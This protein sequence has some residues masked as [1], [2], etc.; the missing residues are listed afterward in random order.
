MAMLWPYVFAQGLDIQFA[1]TSFP[2]SNNA[3]KNAGVTCVVVGIGRGRDKYIFTDALKRKVSSISP[4]L[5]E[6]PPTVVTKRSASVSDL[7][8]M[9]TGNLPSDGGHLLMTYS[10]GR[11]LVATHPDAK[12][13]LKK[14]VGSRELIN[15]GDRWCLWIDDQELPEALKID[16]IARRLTGV[17]AARESSRGDQAKGGVATPHRFVFSPHRSGYAV[18]IPKVSSA[19]REYIPCALTDDDTVVS[20]LARVI[21]EAPVWALALVASRLHLVWIATICGKLKTDF[22]YS[23]TLGWN[24]FPVPPLSEKNRHDLRACA[25]SILLVREA[26]F[27][28]TLAELYDPDRMPADLRDAHQRNDEVIERIYIGRRFRNDTERLEKL[29]ELYTKSVGP[30]ADKAKAGADA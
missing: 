11:R 17:R 29:F 7:P 28:A 13:F 8:R 10:E 1:H 22:R 2:W 30:V 9:V 4:Y 25:E 24:T 5:I 12:R 21:Y 18:A 27:P 15:G 14:F 20:D 23:N 16:D 6:G 3:A 26:H 19:R